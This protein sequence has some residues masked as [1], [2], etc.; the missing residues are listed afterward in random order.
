MQQLVNNLLVSGG[1]DVDLQGFGAR[2]ELV[3]KS[4]V[5]TKQTV[6]QHRLTD[7]ASQHRAGMKTYTH[8]GR[9]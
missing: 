2:L 6:L 9:K 4:D 3:G 7:D 1:T 5:V 8:L